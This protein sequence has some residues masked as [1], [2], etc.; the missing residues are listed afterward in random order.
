MEG[1]LM[2]LAIILAP[3]I[4][5]LLKNTYMTAMLIAAN[6]GLFIFVNF[7]IPGGW[8]GHLVL[9]ELAFN[10]QLFLQGK[11]QTV[12]TSIFLHITPMH[13]IFNLIF[14]IFWGPMMEHRIGARRLLLVYVLTGVAAGL[15]YSLLHWNSY[16]FALGASGALFGIAG[17][18]VAMYPQER[19]SVILLFIPLRNV[20][21]YVIIVVML[22]IE[23]FLFLS[24]PHS[25]IAHEAHLGG[26]AAGL[27]L[28]TVLA[29]Q[30]PQGSHIRQIVLSTDALIP[31]AVTPE[32]QDMLQH[33]RGSQEPEII[34]AWAESFLERAA[35]PKCGKGLGHNAAWK[36]LQGS[37]V[38]PCGWKSGQDTV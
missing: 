23:A 18:F 28:G 21:G 26:L 7:A 22:M 12:F 36:A 34:K 33:L 1:L 30:L 17:C 31:L 4:F 2:A 10:P 27:A 37:V 32:L 3:L 9:V 14:L 25:N 29:K 13:I 15:L 5:A 19:M 35:C 38:C 8:E 20:K 11:V 24:Y 6:I 16:R